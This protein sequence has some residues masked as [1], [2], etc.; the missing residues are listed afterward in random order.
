MKRITCIILIFFIAN[1][2]FA[3][4]DDYRVYRSQG[5]QKFQGGFYDVAK[6]AYDLALRFQPNDLYV[7]NQIKKCV[8]LRKAEN[9]YKSGQESNAEL[10]FKNYS[11]QPCANYYLGLIEKNKG[12]YSKA[13]D[14]LKVADRGGYYLASVEISVVNAL[15]QA[16]NE[17]FKLRAAE[18]KLK[19]KLDQVEKSVD[20]S[21][22]AKAL[23]E[24]KNAELE[25]QR[26]EDQA[27]ITKLEVE[28]SNNQA[29]IE[30]LKIEKEALE[31]NNAVQEEIIRQ[32]SDEDGDGVILI[33]DECPYE[34]GEKINGCPKTNRFKLELLGGLVFPYYEIGKSTGTYNVINR[35]D[36]EASNYSSELN[37]KFQYGLRFDVFNPYKVLN[38]MWDIKYQ[39]KGFLAL[40]DN[41]I[42][43]DWEFSSVVIPVYFKIHFPTTKRDVDASEKKK[44]LG[45]PRMMILLGGV[46]AYNFDATVGQSTNGNENG[47]F[48]NQFNFGYTGGLGFEGAGKI[49][50][51]KLMI[52]FDQF[53]DDLFDSTKTVHGTSL[54]DF[55][56]DVM[57]HF[58][59]TLSFR[60][61]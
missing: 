31:E 26:Q 57:S 47:E 48:M 7:K 11:N 58:G 54:N 44:K 16:E 20:A 59:A 17:S 60:F 51:I 30:K 46:G 27:K 28:R 50:G 24:A 40:N 53:V 5:D 21:E 42:V 32:Q 25:V 39:Q 55:S 4:N 38:M 10:I 43:E 12:Q 2:L 52:T 49:G 29:E 33:M 34:K 3:Q 6:Q 56:S 22:K 37:L 41:I 18:E 9:Y 15:L 35:F 14:Y 36:S 45:R 8:D 1:I 13:L 23:L 19:S 61:W